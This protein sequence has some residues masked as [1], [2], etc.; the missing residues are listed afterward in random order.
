MQAVADAIFDP[1]DWKNPIYAKFPPCG[2][3]WAKAAV[4]WYHGAEPRESFIGVYSNG[5]QCY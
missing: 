2:I 3:E 1:A 5:Y 4:I